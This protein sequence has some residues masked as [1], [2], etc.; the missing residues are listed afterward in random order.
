MTSTK[1]LVHQLFFG[2]NESRGEHTLLDASFS[3]ASARDAWASKLR[4]HTR[5]KV[6]GGGEVPP[7]AFSYLRF[8][9][10]TAAVITRFADGHSAGRGDAHA[11]TGTAEVLTPEIAM[12][13]ESWPEWQARSSA[14]RPPREITAAE[15]AAV[16]DDLSVE[17]ANRVRGLLGVVLTTMLPQPGAPISIINCREE[18]KVPLLRAIYVAADVYLRNSLGVNRSWTFST[19][20]HRHG[21]TLENLPELVFLSAW[22]DERRPNRVHVDLSQPAVL[23]AEAQRLVDR[24]FDQTGAQPST[25]NQVEA[26]VPT[27]PSPIARR[28][29]PQPQENA[30]RQVAQPAATVSRPA[31]TSAVDA[32][33]RATSMAE[34]QATLDAVARGGD[35]LWKS[36]TVEDIDRLTDR[37]DQFALVDSLVK[38]GHACYGT[39]V[40][41]LGDPQARRHA[42]DVIAQSHSTRF[43]NMLV[44]SLLANPHQD[45]ID[46]LRKRLQGKAWE[47]PSTRPG[48]FVGRAEQLLRQHNRWQRVAIIL[49]SV[50]TVFVVGLFVGRSLVANQSTPTATPQTTLPTKANVPAPT[51]T[52]PD[53]TLP[54]VQLQ[55]EAIDVVLPVAEGS[56]LWSF[57]RTATGVYPQMQCT[58]TSPRK[59]VCVRQLEHKGLYGADGEFLFAVVTK[60]LLATVAANVDKPLQDIG[61][62]YQRVGG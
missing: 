47:A 48:R 13:L 3:G 34:F 28:P 45:V 53:V 7:R 22:P 43:T 51:T 49:L 41:N 20:E 12:G 30:V 39:Q 57:V 9:D 59:W 46:A 23:S 2:F 60:D 18:D 56:K 11:L 27:V 19:F 6:D 29:D 33:L 24:M 25:A 14:K 62:A 58:D 32:L 40:E 5:L 10:G 15:L 26:P 36:T 1:L 35:L 50:V 8:A 38:L 17:R 16:A 55:S 42:M 31:P 21:D 4:N 61:L 37:I 54:P 52:Q 44:A